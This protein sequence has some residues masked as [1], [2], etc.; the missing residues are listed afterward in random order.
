MGEMADWHIDAWDCGDTYEDPYEGRT[1]CKY[2][3]FDEL[4][5]EQIDEKWRL[6][7][8]EGVIHT[9]KEYRGSMG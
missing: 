4:F 7:D 1:T 8:V 9:C 2:C 3:G 5:W 6:V